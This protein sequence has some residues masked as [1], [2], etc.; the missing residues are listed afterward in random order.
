MLDQCDGKP[1]IWCCLD[2]SGGKSV[3]RA[4]AHAVRHSATDGGFDE[5]GCEEGE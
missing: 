4:T 2:H 1:S 3:R 5:I